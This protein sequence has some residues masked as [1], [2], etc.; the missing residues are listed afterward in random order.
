M[1]S[2]HDI[3][4]TPDEWRDAAWVSVFALL[5][6]FPSKEENYNC[7]I[8]Q[9]IVPRISNMINGRSMKRK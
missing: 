1:I 6:D 4:C 7:P 8:Y 3:T 2:T 9:N 5:L